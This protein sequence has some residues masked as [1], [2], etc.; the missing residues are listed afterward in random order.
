KKRQNGI[1]NVI[2]KLKSSAPFLPPGDPDPVQHLREYN[3][4]LSPTL[5]LLSVDAWTLVSTVIRNMFLNWLVLVPLL[6][7]ALMLPR[8]VLSLAKLGDTYTSYGHWLVDLR[9]VLIWVFP[10]TAGLFFAVGIFN[11][12]RYLPQLGG[13]NRSQGHFLKYV[14][15][16]L[17]GSAMAF[18]AL[19]AWFT[20]GDATG[21][22]SLTYPE[23][24]AGISISGGAAWIAYLLIFFRKVAGKR[25]TVLGLS[26]A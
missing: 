2:P 20:G 4:Y 10:V 23:L 19:E 11:A 1:N 22:S 13:E 14:L 21:P 12:L 7:F 6:M 9:A 24:L 26:F 25:G 15:G 8:V 17:I 18:I 16:P 3:S 5:G